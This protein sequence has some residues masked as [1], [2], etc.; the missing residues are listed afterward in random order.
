[1]NPEIIGAIICGTIT[2]G[3]LAFIYFIYKKIMRVPEPETK[4]EEETRNLITLPNKWP[5]ENTT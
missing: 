5:P 2:G 1:M 4:P 3:S